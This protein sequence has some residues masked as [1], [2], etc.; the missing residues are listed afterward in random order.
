MH[1]SDLPTDC[2]FTL[3]QRGPSPLLQ[4]SSGKGHHR[5]GVYE[6]LRV[7]SRFTSADELIEGARQ[8]ISPD[9]LVQVVEITRR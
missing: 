2:T 1:F 6:I 4:K 3:V 8:S 7:E 9:A 5:A